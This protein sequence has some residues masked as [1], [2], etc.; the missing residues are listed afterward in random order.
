M[1]GFN[2]GDKHAKNH[3]T[4]WWLTYPSEKYEFVSWDDYS[5]DMEKSKNAPNHQ[6]VR[7]L[8]CGLEH[9]LIFPYLGNNHPN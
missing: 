7:L 8:V 3:L 4:G 6:P 2:L 5:Q 9:V 1:V